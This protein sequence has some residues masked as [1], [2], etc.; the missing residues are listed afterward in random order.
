MNGL[1]HRPWRL[2]S[3]APQG[4]GAGTG[5]AV[6]RP[7]L[8]YIRHGLTDWNTEGRLQGRHD[9]PLNER[10]RKQA[11]ECAGILRDLFARDGRAPDE[12]AYVSSPLLRARETMEIV[13]ADLGLAPM[14][15][16][17]EPRLAEIAFGDWEG[18]TYLDVIARDKDIVDKREHDK[19]LFRPPGGET[20]DE[21]AQ[22][23]GA[24]YAALDRDAVVAAHGG[25]ARALAAWLGIAPPERA[26][27]QSIEQ[28]VVYVF[29]G[30]TLTRYA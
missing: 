11:R 8:Y 30:R 4:D 1:D 25:T 3:L 6:K 22:R 21:V 28:G 29:A 15:F 16:A 14:G 23:V 12:F 9:V 10:G 13:R 24:W 7:T 17:V 26:V 5:R 18:L 2:A 19:W 20:Y 27:H